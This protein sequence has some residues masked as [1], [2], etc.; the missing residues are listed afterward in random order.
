MPRAELVADAEVTDEE[1]RRAQILDAAMECFV[2]LGIARTSV[3]DVA[4]M[5]GVSR[6]T[7]YRYF[8]DR[9]ILIDAAVER[10]ARAYYRDAAAAMD[11]KATLAE[12]AGA[13]AEVAAQTLI[14]HK[15]R[16]RLIADDAELMRHMVSGSDATVR[17]TT[18]FFVPYVEA[19]KLRGEVAK[20]LDVQEASEWLA[21]AINS[22]TSVQT[23]ATF[24]MSKPKVVGRFVSRYAVAGLR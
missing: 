11:K 13:M 6:G 21:R 8:D 20:D 9:K 23:S 14:D 2:Q 4:R 22:L 1:I 17:R 18:E 7:V 19:A 3:Q 15:T 12:Q 24:D 16:N 5:A 10:G